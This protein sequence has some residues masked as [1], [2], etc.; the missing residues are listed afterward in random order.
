MAST[1]SLKSR[2]VGIKVGDNC[3]QLNYCRKY[4]I[5]NTTELDEEQAG[6]DKFNICVN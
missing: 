1:S 3:H 4:C 5:Y 2:F 6:L